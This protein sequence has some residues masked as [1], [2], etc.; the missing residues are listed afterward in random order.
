[1]APLGARE[2]HLWPASVDVAEWLF[3]LLSEEQRERARRF[4]LERDLHR[5]IASREWLRVLLGRYRQTEGAALRFG[6]GPKG[7]PNVGGGPQFNLSHSGGMT[8]LAFCAEEE[9]A[10]TS[11][12]SVRSTMRRRSPAVPL[13]PTKSRGGWR[14]LRPL[15]SKVFFDCWTRMEGVAK[16]SSEGLAAALPPRRHV[17]AV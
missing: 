8:L 4:R 1:M 11:R 16:A 13:L 2:I 6:Y 9:V 10:W 7:K 3:P 12:P 15:R 5:F 14:P 17:A